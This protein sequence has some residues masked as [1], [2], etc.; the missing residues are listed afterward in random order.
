MNDNLKIILEEF[1]KYKGQH[2]IIND[3]V[4]RLIA[5]ATDDDDYYYVLW[6]GRETHWSTCVGTYIP[7]K[8]KIEDRFYNNFINTAKLN[9]YDIIGEINTE[10][11]EY[12]GNGNDVRIKAE[13]VKSPD[14][15]LTPLCWDL[16]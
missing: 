12:I 8:G 5:I 13:S 1:E 7:L 11:W 15:Y 3:T 10:K 16:N 2:V 6:N 9:D 14:R 4:K